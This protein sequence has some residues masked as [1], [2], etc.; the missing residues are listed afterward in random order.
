MESTTGLNCD[1]KVGRDHRNL[2]PSSSAYPVVLYCTQTYIGFSAIQLCQALSS[3]CAFRSGQ[4]RSPTFGPLSIHDLLKRLS[5]L[6]DSYYSSWT[7]IYTN[8]Y[9]FLF[10]ISLF[11]YTASAAAI[12]GKGFKDPNSFEGGSMLTGVY[13]TEPFGQVGLCISQ[14]RKAAHRLNRENR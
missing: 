11:L 14:Y 8:M 4:S 6:F 3:L 10:L 7:A 1:N 13:N 5:S 2:S 12:D 9:R